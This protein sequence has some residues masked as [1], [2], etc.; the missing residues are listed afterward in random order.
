MVDIVLPGSSWTED[1]GTMPNLEDRVLLRRAAQIL[2]GESRLDW[3]I[4]SQL[5]EKLG[6]GSYFPY[7]STKDIFEELRLASA[8][9]KVDYSGITYDK[10]E[11]Q[12][13]I[14]WPCTNDNDL[15]TTEY[16]ARSHKKVIFHPVE[17]TIQSEMKI[18]STLS[19]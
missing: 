3:I 10:L 7:Q 8:G 12:R 11:K 16:F 5:A 15:G 17:Y 13:G 1:G 18:V 9:G 19:T 6:K 2:L 14:F 4:L